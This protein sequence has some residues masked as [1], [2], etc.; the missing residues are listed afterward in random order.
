MESKREMEGV[1][2]S[3]E[4]RERGRERERGVRVLASPDVCLSK[5]TE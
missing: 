5:D 4:E 1:G 2:G 3:K